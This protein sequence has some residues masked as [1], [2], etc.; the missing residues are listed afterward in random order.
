MEIFSGGLY[1]F[2]C[3]RYFEAA[4]GA[5]IGGDSRRRGDRAGRRGGRPLC[6][7]DYASLAAL[8]SSKIVLSAFLMGFSDRLLGKKNV[9]GGPHIESVSPALAPAGGEIRITG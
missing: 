3:L 6:A 7:W 5:T 9:N 2:S 8:W 1:T 4:A